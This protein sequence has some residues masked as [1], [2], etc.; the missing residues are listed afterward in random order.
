M[1][2]KLIIQSKQQIIKMRNLNGSLF[3]NLTLKESN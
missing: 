1:N 2:N 3:E